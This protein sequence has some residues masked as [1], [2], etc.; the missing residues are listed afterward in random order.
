MKNNEEIWD[1]LV[2]NDVLCSRPKFDL[3]PETA[4]T[5]LSRN[6]WYG[7][8]AGKQ[9]LCLACGGGQQSLAFA[10]LG[11]EVTVV[12]FSAEQLKKDQR[13]AD[14]FD[15]SLRIL[16]A[17]MRDLSMLEDASF[18]LVYQPYSIN[19][20]PEVTGVFNEVSRLLKPG[21]IYDLMFHNPY[22]HGTWKDGSWGSQWHPDELWQGKGYPIWQPYRD[23]YPIQ[24][25]DPHWNFTNQDDEEVKIESPQEYRHTMATLINGF[26][27]RGIEILYFQEEVGTE[28]DAEP[29]SWEHYQACAPPWL[30]LVGR[31]R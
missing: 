16:K 23:G 12:D 2:R 5:Y 24:T 26:L 7:D 3:T 29:G 17:D 13:V 19:Y 11:A 4:K 28:R 31:K 18:D 27:Q 6:T 22:V 20:V 10:L 21:G 9:V 14:Q 1:E 15:L 25:V 8:L 30:F